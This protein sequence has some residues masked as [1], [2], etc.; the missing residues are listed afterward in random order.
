MPRHIQFGARK[1]TASPRR[2]VLRVFMLD[3]SQGFFK[4]LAGSFDDPP[5]QEQESASR[6]HVNCH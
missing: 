3:L 6:R 2:L 5:L 1:R 4:T